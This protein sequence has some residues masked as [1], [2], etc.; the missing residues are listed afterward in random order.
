MQ[1]S[2]TIDLND[3]GDTFLSE[4]DSE[5]ILDHSEGLHLYSGPRFPDNELRW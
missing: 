3:A 5:S 1:G 2:S 4:N